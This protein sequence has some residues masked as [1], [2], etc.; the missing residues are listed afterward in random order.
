MASK[1]DVICTVN[2]E[3]YKRTQ[4]FNVEQVRY[5]HG[6]GINTARL[7]P[8]KKQNDIRLE[9]GLNKDD[10]IVLSVGELNENKNQK[11]IIEALSVLNDKKIHYLLCGK[12]NQADALK[13]L[14]AERHLEQNVHFLGYRKDVVDICS[15]SDVYVM[16]SKREGLPVASLEAMYCGLPLVTSNIRGL[17][18]V[19]ENGKSGY[20]CSP[21]D[22][23]GFAEGIKCLKA[24]PKMRKEMGERNRETVKPYCIEET[25]KEVLELLAEL[26]NERGK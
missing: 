14:V 10:F 13:K 6:I 12:G 9:L 19:M 23:R 15:Q 16:P 8:G 21:D 4:K 7:T 24:N 3:D 11:V 20:M 1:A 2:R 25:K 26:Y 22:A 5:I 17:T 18:D